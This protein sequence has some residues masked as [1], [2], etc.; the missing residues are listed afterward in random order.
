MRAMR[1]GW[2]RFCTATCTGRETVAS[3]RTADSVA[4]SACGL[5]R[6]TTVFEEVRIGAPMRN[7]AGSRLSTVR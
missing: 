6:T 4:R 1:P 2:P 5:V 3:A 7:G